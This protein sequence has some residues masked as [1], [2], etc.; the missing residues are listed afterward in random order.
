LND[1]GLS[2]IDAQLSEKDKKQLPGFFNALPDC[3][4]S[5]AISLSAK[6]YEPHFIITEILRHAALE[7]QEAHE[8]A[9]KKGL[10]SLDLLARGTNAIRGILGRISAPA[11]PSA[12]MK[13]A[14]PIGTTEQNIYD[15]FELR[16]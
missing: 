5:T 3:Q 10:P 7:E 12:L 15:F 1:I 4:T 2:D 8:E 9:V 13:L 16:I 14:E 11:P 6:C